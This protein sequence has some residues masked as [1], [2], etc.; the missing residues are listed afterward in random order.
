MTSSATFTVQGELKD[1]SS[2]HLLGN[3]HLFWG[4]GNWFLG[5]ESH[6]VSKKYRGTSHVKEAGYSSRK[7]EIIPLRETDLDTDPYSI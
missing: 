3:R 6:S 5:R 7:F 1:A 2:E 4:P